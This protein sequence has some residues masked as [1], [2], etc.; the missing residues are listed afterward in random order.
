MR[1]LW[2]RNLIKKMETENFYIGL[3]R[4]VK[5][6]S[7]NLGVN[8]HICRNCSSFR[9]SFINLSIDLIFYVRKKND[10]KHN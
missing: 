4:I 5:E 10:R 9:I 1:I 2:N 6:Q 3:I 8:L 7:F